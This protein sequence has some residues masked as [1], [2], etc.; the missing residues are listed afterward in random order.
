MATSESQSALPALSPLSL[1]STPVI[2]SPLRAQEAQSENH[3][4]FSFEDSF[5]SNTWWLE[6]HAILGRTRAD[7]VPGRGMVRASLDLV[8][9]TPHPPPCLVLLL[10]RALSQAVTVTHPLT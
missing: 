6:Y 2:Y 8:F 4:L 9:S 7:V 10:M 1:P 5:G 3:L